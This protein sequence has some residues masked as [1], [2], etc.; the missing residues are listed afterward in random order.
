MEMEIGSKTMAAV[1]GFFLFVSRFV[2]RRTPLYMG[3]F[4]EVVLFDQ[5]KVAPA[6]RPELYGRSLELPPYSWSLNSLTALL[7]AWLLWGAW[8][9]AYLL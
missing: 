3:V 4:T 5:A 6:I 7:E 2:S 1:D 8:K 9:L